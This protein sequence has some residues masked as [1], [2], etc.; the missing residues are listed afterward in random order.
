MPQWE[1]TL[2]GRVQGVGFRNFARKH[3]LR[4]GLRGYVRNLPGGS[5]RIVADADDQTLD[6]YCELLRR[7]SVFARVDTLST[8]LIDKPKEY[9]DFEI[10]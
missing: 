7:G 10:Q 2:Q 4:L 9:Y 8:K 5:V 3:A 6:L 1:I